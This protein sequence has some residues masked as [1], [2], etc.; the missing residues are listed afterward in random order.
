MRALGVLI[1]ITMVAGAPLAT[2]ETL[3]GAWN[4]HWVSD[5]RRGQGSMGLVL[6]RTPGKDEVVGQF[7]FVTGGVTRSLRY[8]GRIEDGRVEFPLVGDGRI[9]LEPL[10]AARPGTAPR[11]RGSWRDARG[12]LP[13]PEGVIDLGRAE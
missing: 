2:V 8:E 4:G 9:V 13:A 5:D 3:L 12:A 11:L 6:A 10:G 7:T 1:A